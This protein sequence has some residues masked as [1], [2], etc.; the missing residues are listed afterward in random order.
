MQLLLDTH[1]LVWLLEDSA[2]IAEPIHAQ[3]QQGADED[4]LFVSAIT[5]WEIAMLVAKGKLR[6]S[7]D[8]AEWISAALSLPGIHL[9]PLSPAIAVASTR[10]PWE[11]HGDPA[12]RILL[13][14]ARHLDAT[15]VTADS[16]ILDYGTLGFVKCISPN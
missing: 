14:T 6:L 8:V 13:A 16:Q 4:R 3:L 9:E 2:R 12:D 10:L 1:M 7:R 11:C 15:L 5:P